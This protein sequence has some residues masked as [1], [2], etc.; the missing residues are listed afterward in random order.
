M[1]RRLM[2]VGLSAA[3]AAGVV[4]AAAGAAHA[5]DQIYNVITD[6]AKGQWNAT[7]HVMTVTDTAADGDTAY[8]YI[9]K[10][11]GD[12]IYIHTTGG[13]GSS[14]SES[15]GSFYDIGG[16]IYFEVARVDSAGHIINDSQYVNYAY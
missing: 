9:E 6:G 2:S 1:L 5:S 3:V 4:V 15:I 11:N 13:S 8:V 7:K 10:P 14:A 16:Y 12:F